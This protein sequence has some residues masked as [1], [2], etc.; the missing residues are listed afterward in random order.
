MKGLNDKGEFQASGSDYSRIYDDAGQSSAVSGAFRRY[1]R[2]IYLNVF[3]V[4]MELLGGSLAKSF[5]VM[6]EGSMLIIDIFTSV[7]RICGAYSMDKSKL[8]GYSKE[9]IWTSTLAT[10]ESSL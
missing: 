8:Y 9:K 6:S 10:E 3:F 7:I 5:A 4:V 2:V 1:S